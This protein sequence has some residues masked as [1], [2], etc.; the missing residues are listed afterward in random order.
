MTNVMTMNAP[1]FRRSIGFDRFGELFDS[2]L[3]EKVDG[4]DSY[5]PH[6]IE[7]FSDDSYRITMAVAGFGIG[8]LQVTLNDDT[9]VIAGAHIGLSEQNSDHADEQI[10]DRDGVD[11]I[12]VLHHGIAS[13]AF[14]R[15]FR[16]ADQIKVQDAVLKDGLLTITL[17]HKIPVEKKPRL[18]KIKTEDAKIGQSKNG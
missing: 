14:E 12:E 10:N 11:L 15:S 16:L 18:I 8:D 13:R 9:L 2:I 1:L 6:N 4:H 7:K 5:P 3:D 17:R